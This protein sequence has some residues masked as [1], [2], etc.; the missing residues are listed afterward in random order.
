M[1]VVVYLDT[2]VLRDILAKKRGIETIPSAC[3]KG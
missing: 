1:G 2:S 3:L